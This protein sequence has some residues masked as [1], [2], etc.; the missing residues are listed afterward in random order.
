MRVG[1]SGRLQID[2][3]QPGIGV[4]SPWTD[5]TKQSEFVVR[6]EFYREARRSADR[7]E[8]GDACDNRLLDKLET[9][10]SAHQQNSRFQRH[11]SG[12]KGGAHHLVDRV[13]SSDILSR[14][15]QLTPHVEKPGGVK[16]AGLRKEGL[17]F[18]QSL[19]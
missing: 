18:A 12:K 1:E 2:A 3:V 14:S 16:P 17:S 6:R 5:K 19:G 8:D 15:H 4:E 9:G 11:L 10:A 13:V 7:R